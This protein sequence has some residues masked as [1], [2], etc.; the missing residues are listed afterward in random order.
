M[1]KISFNLSD[2]EKRKLELKAQSLG[3]TTS[4]FLRQIITHSLKKQRNSDETQKTVKAIRGLIPVLSEALGRTQG[5]ADKQI[6]KLTKIL[7]DTY[8]RGVL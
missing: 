7:L 1:P 2:D 4:G 3:L 5:A 8:D 6:A